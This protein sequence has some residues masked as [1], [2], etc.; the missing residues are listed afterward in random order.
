MPTQS[1]SVLSAFSFS[2][3]ADIQWLS[4]GHPSHNF[5]VIAEFFLYV[6]MMLLICWC[7]IVVTLFGAFCF[8]HFGRFFKH[9]VSCDFACHFLLGAIF[10]A[11]YTC[12]GYYWMHLQAI[13]CSVIDA[14][15][16]LPFPVI[17][18]NCQ[19]C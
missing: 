14:F 3:L 11:L 15:C 6:C 19:C 4:S 12:T 5:S 18:E 9:W 13:R 16:L 10:Y 17:Q 7:V 8:G 2:R 1:S